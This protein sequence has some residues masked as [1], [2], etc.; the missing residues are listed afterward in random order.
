MTIPPKHL[1]NVIKKD[2]VSFMNAVK[3]SSE[4]YQKMSQERQMK[5]QFK[6]PAK[7]D[8]TGRVTFGKANAPITIVEYSDFQCPYCARAATTMKSLIKK[9]KGKVKL[10]Y[11]HFPLGFHPFAKPASVYFEAIAMIDHEKARKFHDMIFDNFQEYARLKGE[12]DINKKLRKLV[13]SVGANW[14]EVEKNLSKARA[15]V[16][17]DKK[18]GEGLQVRGTPSFFI[19]GVKPGSGGFEPVI[20]HFLNKL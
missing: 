9:Y 4:R 13:K 12:K 16:E 17:A 6:N 1:A 20:E 5:E 10:V 15:Q 11:K 14:S 8:V 18:E 3:V 7:I 2:P 19:N